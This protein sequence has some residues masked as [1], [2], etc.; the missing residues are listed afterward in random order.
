[1]SDFYEAFHR[2]HPTGPPRPGDRF[3]AAV[4]ANLTNTEEVAAAR[5][6]A[7][8]EAAR[9]PTATDAGIGTAGDRIERPTGA[10]VFGAM[11]H[12]VDLQ[13]YP[14]TRI[15]PQPHR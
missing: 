9:P 4:A 11:T 12:A 15:N 14:L 13:R 8:A 10:D 1:M 3:T 5:A 2:E 6:T 7:S